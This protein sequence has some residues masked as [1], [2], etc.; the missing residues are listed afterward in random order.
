MPLDR[1]GPVCLAG[2]RP[3]SRQCYRRVWRDGETAGRLRSNGVMGKHA[4]ASRSADPGSSSQRLSFVS[5][6]SFSRSDQAA[7]VF[8]GV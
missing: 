6:S 8:V 4:R 5:A 2:Y 3:K 7:Q 1:I